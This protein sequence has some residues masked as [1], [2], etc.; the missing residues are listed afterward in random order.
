MCIKSLADLLVIKFLGG[1]VVP[2]A[3]NEVGTYIVAA[4]TCKE[5]ST[6]IYNL[7]DDETFK[8]WDIDI[9]PYFVDFYGATVTC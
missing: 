2:Y 1:Q 7:I 4:C 5:V 9:Q 6:F 8:L 3:N